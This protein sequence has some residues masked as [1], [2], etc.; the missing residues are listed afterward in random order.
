MTVKTSEGQ[1]LT[2]CREVNLVLR[3]IFNDVLDLSVGRVET[4]RTD[5][6]A[7]YVRFE[8]T[9]AVPV[10][11]TEG[12]LEVSNL[13]FGEVVDGLG[14]VS[15]RGRERVPWCAFFALGGLRSA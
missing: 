1:C 8:S 3:Q 13:L 15:E 14:H 11:K 9:V 4:K 2:Y 5:G 12:F 7:Q 10:K 6:G